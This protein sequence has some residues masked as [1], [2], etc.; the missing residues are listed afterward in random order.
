ML[1]FSYILLRLLSHRKNSPTSSQKKIFLA[2]KWKTFSFYGRICLKT[3]FYSQHFSFR[4]Y[5]RSLAR[6]SDGIRHVRHKD[7]DH[8]QRVELV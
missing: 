3:R 6:S 2:A 4:A 7:M 8:F 5:V 1:R